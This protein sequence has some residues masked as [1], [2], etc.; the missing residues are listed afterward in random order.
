MRRALV[1]TL[2]RGGARTDLVAELDESLLGVRP[3]PTSSVPH[4]RLRKLIS[5]LGTFCASMAQRHMRS[6]AASVG[7]V[8]KERAILERLE[9]I[10]GLRQEDAPAG[11]LLDE[12]RALLCEA[13]D[14]VR[15]ERRSGAGCGSS[16]SLEGGAR[17]RRAAERQVA[18]RPLARKIARK[19][20]RILFGVGIF[21]HN[22]C[23]QDCTS[24]GRSG[25]T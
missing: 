2:T 20:R 5:R 10:D 1:E 18:L 19:S 11:V 15:D 9:R 13:E 17:G 6:S 22:G 12:V 23:V 24:T 25:D 7:A 8:E 3:K 14:W 21:L 4:A 16:G